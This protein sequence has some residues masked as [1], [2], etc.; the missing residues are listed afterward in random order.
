[1]HF[2]S[3]RYRLPADQVSSSR[4]HAANFDFMTGFKPASH[5]T[6]SMVAPHLSKR[7]NEPVVTGAAFVPSGAPARLS[8]FQE[9]SAGRAEYRLMSEQQRREKEQDP[10]PP[11][12]KERSTV[13][14]SSEEKQRK[15]VARELEEKIAD[16]D[17][18]LK[19]KQ[20]ETSELASSMASESQPLGDIQEISAVES[21][22]VSSDKYSSESGQNAIRESDT[23]PEQE[24][25][26][27]SQVMTS[28]QVQLSGANLEVQDTQRREPHHPGVLSKFP[29]MKVG[30]SLTIP[31]DRVSRLIGDADVMHRFKLVKQ[32]VHLIL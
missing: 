4:P 8:W 27:D 19:Q 3:F 23:G 29:V 9:D 17:V 31:S 26:G 12:I 21:T 7:T 16:G 32:Y 24:L 11:K 10:S 30:T 2:L 13:K 22:I 20:V 28:K 1:M 25:V 15:A 14:K 6:P 18:G 5:H